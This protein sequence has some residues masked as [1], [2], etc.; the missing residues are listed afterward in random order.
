MKK[1]IKQKVL[2]LTKPANSNSV[3]NQDHFICAHI[4]E[5]ITKSCNVH[6]SP[7]DCPDFLVVYV[8]EYREYGL[9][10]RDG[11]NSSASSYVVIN[12][13]PWCGKKLPISLREKYFDILEKEYGLDIAL[14]DIEDNP[15]IPEEFK[16]D[17]WWK[18]RKL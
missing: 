14:G 5:E 18:K 10:I 2:V 7:L 17:E 1:N 11:K 3:S 6:S 4:A 12:Y 9:P 16:S 13:C 15:N 8:P